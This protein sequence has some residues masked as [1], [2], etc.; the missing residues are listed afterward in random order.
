HGCNYGHQLM[1]EHN[2]RILRAHRMIGLSREDLLVMLLQ[3]DSGLLPPVCVM[4][5]RG[6]GPHGNCQDGE[7]DSSEDAAATRTAAA[8]TIS[9]SLTGVSNQL[10]CLLPFIYRNILTLKTL[11]TQPDR[12]NTDVQPHS[13]SDG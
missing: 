7:K 13:S 5:N 9:K 10:M 11:K 6:Q 3:S 2:V 4:Y 12:R 8:H 1:S